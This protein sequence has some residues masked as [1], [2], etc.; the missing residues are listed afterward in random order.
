MILPAWH[1]GWVLSFIPLFM[2]DTDKPLIEELIRTESKLILC[3]QDT[4]GQAGM[5]HAIAYMDGI[6][7]DT[8]SVI[9]NQHDLKIDL[10]GLLKRRHD[11]RSPP[12]YLPECVR[13][14][15]VAAYF[16]RKMARVRN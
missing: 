13:D 15:C 11:V 8:N 7:I 12:S 5:P 1:F 9:R 3:G 4:T 6:F 2:L 10:V 14:A 16:E